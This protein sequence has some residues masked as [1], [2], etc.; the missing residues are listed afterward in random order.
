[1]KY[2]LA[3]YSV[4]PEKVKELK[5]AV[6]EF[7]SEVK[8]NEPRTLYLVFREPTAHSF[9]HWMCFENDAAE[10]RHS[11]SRYNQFFVRRLMECCA[12]KPTFTEFDLFSSSRKH[13]PLP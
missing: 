3:R 6:A 12:G 13:W 5:R 8:K 4:R 7:I 1:M 10:R 9:A 2:T 11:Q